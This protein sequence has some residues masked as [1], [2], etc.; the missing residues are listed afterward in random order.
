VSGVVLTADRVEGK[1]RHLITVL[2]ERTA[3][4]ASAE[5]AFGDT[6]TTTTGTRTT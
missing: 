1:R 3:D 4:L 5:Q 2:A 6:D